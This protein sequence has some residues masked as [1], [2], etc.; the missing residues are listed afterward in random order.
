MGLDAVFFT[1]LNGK[2]LCPKREDDFPTE[3]T[4]ILSQESHTAG[5]SRVLIRNKK[6]IGFAPIIEKCICVNREDRFKNVAEL[7]AAIEKV[8]VTSVP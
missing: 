4:S 8:K 7:R 5:N 2:L 1:D 6:M 3:L